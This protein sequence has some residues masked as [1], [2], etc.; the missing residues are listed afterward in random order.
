VGLTTA[1]YSGLQD[2]Y[3]FADTGDTIQSKNTT[4]SEILFID[5]PT[6]KTTYFEAGYDCAFTSIIDW[7]YLIGDMTVSDGLFVLQDGT[8]DLQ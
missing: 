3:D 7:T 1:Y 2:A 6:A 5:D 8:L 4:F